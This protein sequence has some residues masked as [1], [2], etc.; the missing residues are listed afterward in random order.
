MIQVYSSGRYLTSVH[1]IAEVR[2]IIKTTS[3]VTIKRDR[4]PF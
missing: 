1:T 4:T 2:A 3:S